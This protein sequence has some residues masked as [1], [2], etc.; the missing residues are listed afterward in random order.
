MVISPLTTGGKSR[1]PDSLLTADSPSLA[2]ER[3]VWVLAGVAHHVP[4]LEVLAG[5]D[6]Q[7]LPPHLRLALGWP[8]GGTTACNTGGVSYFQILEENLRSLSS[9]FI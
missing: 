5:G 9:Y 7:P 4:R 3:E 1:P 6:H 2:Q 8:A